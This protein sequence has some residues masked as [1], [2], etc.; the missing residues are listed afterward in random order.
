[1]TRQSD[2]TGLRAFFISFVLTVLTF[3]TVALS[4]ILLLQNQNASFQ[5]GANQD[6]SAGL[7]IQKEDHTTLFYAALNSAAPDTFVLVRYDGTDDKIYVAALPR[8]LRCGGVPL[9][10]Y[11]SDGL[12][13]VKNALST[14][15][16]IT[17]DN[18]VF[19]GRSDLSM[20]L[21]TL[22]KINLTLNQ[23]LTYQDPV[24]GFSFTLEKG[25]QSLDENTAVGLLAGTAE[26][27]EEGTRALNASIV[28]E[29]ILQCTGYLCE[30]TDNLFFNTLL[31]TAYDDMNSVVVAK[32]IN[33]LK[34]LYAQTDSFAAMVTLDYT[35]QEGVPV[36]GEKNEELLELYFR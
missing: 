21:S 2:K 18:A 9:S 19:L 17:I 33:I 8:A 22:G 11:Q 31:N 15:L 1:M 29:Y 34:D 7:S 12:Q 35:E 28:T 27:D 4:V 36:P 30:D 23:Q 24:S 14:E 32:I 20:V 13:T 26:L 3:G 25:A 10:S 6:S 16:N 5:A